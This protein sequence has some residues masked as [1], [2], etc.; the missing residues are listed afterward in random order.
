MRSAI[1]SARAVG[2]KSAW[3]PK[4]CSIVA[5]NDE[6][7]IR[8]TIVA[9]TA[10]IHQKAKQ[11]LSSVPDPKQDL[12]IAIDIAHHFAPTTDFTSFMCSG[13]HMARFAK[14]ATLQNKTTE[15]HNNRTNSHGE[16]VPAFPCPFQFLS[17]ATTFSHC[18]V[19]N[20]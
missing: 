5:M 1:Y 11:I 10:L 17:I 7:A 12:I 6:E 2:I 9:H 15:R 19:S 16:L 8:D 3:Q 14:A 4:P 20:L 18:L 13:T